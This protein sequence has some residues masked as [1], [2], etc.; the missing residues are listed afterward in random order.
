[1]TL[2]EYLR[3]ELDDPES[4]FSIGINGAIAEFFRNADEPGAQTENGRYAVCTPRGGMHVR[5]RGDVRPVA[6]ETPGR[7]P[8]HW[9]QRVVCCL[10]KESAAMGN[11]QSLTALGA[12]AEAIRGADRSAQLFDLGLGI[13]HVDACIRTADEE[14]IAMLRAG[15]EGRPL[16]DAPEVVAAIIDKS[17][18]RV[19]VSALGRIEVYTPIPVD[20]TVLGPHT[21]ILPH[22]LGKPETAAAWLPRGAVACLDV[23][24]ANPARD[25]TGRARPFDAARHAR[26]QRALCA[27]GPPACVEEKR[28][29]EAWIRQGVSPR[30]CRPAGNPLARAGRLVAV[31]QMAFT[32]PDAPQLAVWRRALEKAGHAGAAPGP[33][34]R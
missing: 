24:P 18:H 31:R 19:F 29:V 25:L 11:R 9:Q 7:H 23:Y 17:P 28:R 3:R 20:H 13:A 14:L 34:S 21:H 12:D 33:E 30:N 10:G 1:M 2:D 6:I 16:H 8:D 4:G 5:L 15:L 27:W 26:F 32:R 22:L